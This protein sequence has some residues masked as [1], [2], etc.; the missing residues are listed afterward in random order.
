MIFK[1]LIRD[2]F[3]VFF[4]I[5]ILNTSAFANSDHYLQDDFGYWTPIYLN[6]PVTDKIRGQFEVNPRIQQNGTHINQLL[7]RPSI[8]YNLTKNWSVWQG[9]AWV[10]NYLPSFVSEQRIW[11]Q[12]L[13]EKH[14]ERVPKLSLIN[15][16]RTEERFIQHINGS[17]FRI[18]NMF[19]LQYALD[20][21]K[22]WSFVLFDE[23]F[24]NIG[25]HDNGPQSG[26][27][28][29][30][31]FAGINRKF[32]SHCNAEAGYLMQYINTPNSGVDKL[33]HNIL[34]NVYFTTPQLFNKK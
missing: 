18:R 9:Y 21:D 33:N 6:V 19:R 28:Q 12:L 5:C 2:L 29:N 16:F 10:T 27:D 13:Y 31:F 34:V 11:Q 15:R 23:P 20:K 22:K 24:V 8:G 4:I 26:V 3:F 32:N 30:R 17:P 7:V 1:R 14:F 25:S